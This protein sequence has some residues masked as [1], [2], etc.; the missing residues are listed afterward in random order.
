MDSQ[1]LRRGAYQAGIPNRGKRMHKAQAGGPVSCPFHPRKS[2]WRGWKVSPQ[3]GEGRGGGPPPC[4][5]LRGQ[6][7][8]L[9]S[10]DAWP[11]FISISF[12][13]P[14]ILYGIPSHPR[15]P[16]L[17]WRKGPGRGPPQPVPPT[18]PFS[19]GK[20]NGVGRRRRRGLAGQPGWREPLCV[21]PRVFA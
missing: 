6:L 14:F 16:F 18:L 13:W 17:P 12:A 19:R 15:S 9:L 7:P 2:L 11:G 1:T 21:G 20:D 10:G 5:L 3:K 4:G 8:R